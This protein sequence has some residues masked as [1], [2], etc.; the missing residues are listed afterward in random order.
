M[1]TPRCRTLQ[2]IVLALSCFAL[3]LFAQSGPTT[4]RHDVH[5]DVSQPL[6]EMIKHAPPAS[7]ARRRV[8]SVKLI[9]LPPGLAA[10][11]QDPV[12]QVGAVSPATPPVTLGFE[13]LGNG[14]YGFSVTGAPPDT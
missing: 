9:P 8:E 10:E 2:H 3:P 4:I 11:Q 1:L 5:H 13:G 6:S 12:I 14:Q 7:L